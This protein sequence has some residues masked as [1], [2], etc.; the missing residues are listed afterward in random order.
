AGRNN[1]PDKT[2]YPMRIGKNVGDWPE[3]IHGQFDA[4]HVYNYP[5]AE[6]SVDAPPTI[7]EV[8]HLTNQPESATEYEIT[9][10][11]MQGLGTPVTS[12]TLHYNK[13]NGWQDTPMTMGNDIYSATIL[14]QSLYTIINYYVTAENEDGL[15]SIYPEE[16]ALEEN[17]YYLSFAIEE[18]QTQT[19]ALE[20]EEGSGVTTDSSSYSNLVV[21][22]GSDITYSTDAAVGDYSIVLNG[23]DNYI[24]I[25]SPVLFS[26]EEFSV[27]LWYKPIELRKFWSFILNKPA[28]QPGWWGENTFEI[29]YG[30]WD[31]SEWKLTAGVY[32]DGEQTRITM[33]STIAVD[34]WYHIIAEF[35]KAPEGDAFNYYLFFEL[36]DSN[37]VL[38][39]KNYAG[40]NN[41]PDKTSYPMRIGKN[42]GDWPEFIHGQFDAIHVY[43]YAVSTVSIDKDDTSPIPIEY[44]LSQNYPNPF[45]P[46]TQIRFSIPVQEKVRIDVFDLLGRKIK[47]LVET[48]MTRGS[49]IVLWDGKDEFGSPVATG[50][51][52][53]Q[54]NAGS[55]SRVRKMILL[56]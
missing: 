53:Y 43:N 33:D 42:V 28:I 54:L 41:P 40:R 15:I 24:E 19:L 7:C 36:R 39:Q 9:A 46:V 55:F 29:I 21:I 18:P 11:V 37:D 6:I 3:F 44:E 52:L 2:S 49:Y 26:S 25:P 50:I 5:A 16:A 47:T 14:Q 34:N 1:P 35:R 30:A 20:F 38:I 13:G 27:D 4:I 17:P 45:N 32:S 31:D 22:G 48:D 8:S 12:V 51:Y 56:K 10:N 23:V